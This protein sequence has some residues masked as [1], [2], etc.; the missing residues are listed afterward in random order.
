MCPNH[1]EIP[2]LFSEELLPAEYWNAGLGHY[3][4]LLEKPDVPF[5]IGGE[6]PHIV[7]APIGFSSLPEVAKGRGRK[8]VGQRM[9]KIGGVPSWAQAPEFHTCACGAEMK[10]LLQVRGNFAFRRKPDAPEQPNTFSANAYCLF[11]GNEIYVFA[12]SAQCHPQAVWA[13]VQN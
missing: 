9:V 6:E 7:A 1:N 12:C 11:L 8:A 4:L 2:E 10:F 5:Q 13:V 3:A